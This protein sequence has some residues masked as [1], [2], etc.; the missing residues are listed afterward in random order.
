[1]NPSLLIDLAC[2]Q[3]ASG[4]RGIGRFALDFSLNLI[5]HNPDWLF[6]IA[7]DSRFP[8]SIYQL[9]EVFKNFQNCKPLLFSGPADINYMYDHTANRRQLY[10]KLKHVFYSEHSPDL[11]LI[12]SVFEGYVDDV[13]VSIEEK[14]LRQYKVASV[15]HDFI[16]LVFPLKY[17][18]NSNQ[19]K[20]Y[21]ECLAELKKSDIYLSNSNC[22]KT[23]AQC[24]AHLNAETI[25]TI[26]G[27]CS[28]LFK[29]KMSTPRM[30]EA[31]LLKK[32]ITKPYFLYTGNTDFR[33]NLDGL[34]KAFGQLPISIREN[35]QCIVVANLDDE[36]KLLISNTPGADQLLKRN[37]L[38]FVGNIDDF[39][40][41]YLYEKCYAFVFPSRYEGLGFP[42]L[43]A[44]H[45]EKPVIM[46]N[47]SSL[48]ELGLHPDFAF[49]PESPSQ[50]ANLMEKL[51]T[52][53]EF[54]KQGVQIS[55]DN[56][57]L[58][59]WEKTTALARE[60]LRKFLVPSSS[61]NPAKIQNTTASGFVQKKTLAY[62]S[63]LP[64]TRSGISI[65]SQ[66]LLQEL[67]NEFD[68]TAIVDETEWEQVRKII[69]SPAV[70]DNHWFRTHGGK[71]DI[72]LYQFGNS[73]FHSYMLELMEQWPGV[74]TLHDFFLPNVTFFNQHYSNHCYDSHGYHSLKPSIPPS[75]NRKDEFPVNFGILTQSLGVISHSEFC[76]NL[77]SLWYP[78]AK[79]PPWEIVPILNSFKP[80]SQLKPREKLGIP[81]TDFLICSFGYVD[82]IKLHHIILDAVNLVAHQIQNVHLIFVGESGAEYLASLNDQSKMLANRFKVTGWVEEEDY[83]SFL[84]AS[85][86]VIQLRS[87]PRGESSAALM[88]ALSVGKTVMI[89]DV[90]SFKEIPNDIVLKVSEVPEPKEVAT[91]ILRLTSDPNFRRSLGSK[92]KNHIAAYHSANYCAQLYSK[93]LNQFFQKFLC[94]HQKSFRDTCVDLVI[95]TGDTSLL[96]IS[97]HV[98]SR[99][100]LSKGSAKRLFID[101]T[102]L[103]KQDLKTGIHRVVKKYLDVFLELE[104]KNHRIEPIFSYEGKYRYARNFAK[105]Y[106]NL[107]LHPALDRPIDFHSE[108]VFF[109][110]DLCCTEVLKSRD[111]LW[112][113][114]ATGVKQFFML[115]DI[116]PITNPSFF[117]DEVTGCFKDWVK[118]CLD[119]KAHM[120][121]ISKASIEEL[122]KF[123]LTEFKKTW[124]DSHLR[125]NHLGADFSALSESELALPRK[126]LVTGKDVFLSVGTIEPRKGFDQILSAFDILWSRGFDVGLVFVGKRGWLCEDLINRI[127]KHPQKGK[128]FLWRESISDE[129]LKETYLGSTCYLG[130]SLGEGFGLP[131]IEAAQ[132]ELPLLI[133]DLEVFKEIAGENASYFSGLTGADLAVAVEKWLGD[134]T[135]PEA[136][137][138]PYLSWSDSAKQLWEILWN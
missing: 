23:D 11:V 101:I 4:K 83:A 2:V 105:K 57:K 30:E 66:A 70:K 17:L 34:L 42:V 67:Q 48:K 44:Y 43:E 45:S 86:I 119:L 73:P 100:F 104:D 28:E 68:I 103:Q 6:T 93:A 113:M 99:Q 129:Q 95:K 108:D 79:I 131:L 55:I 107:P 94:S 69:K 8:D 14:T 15:I 27:D 90:G 61:S 81:S 133:R 40:L 56:T 62:V 77:F 92:A 25:T 33:K 130:A 115:Y 12:P 52:S 136:S 1:M 49:D 5:R 31:Y 125:F 85:D 41:R 116:L 112:H 88:D 114:K 16:P 19:K 18:A 122:K 37:N 78:S 51:C 3:G 84:F 126:R 72:V 96:D 64:P 58:F 111:D 36:A 20:W 109:G 134:S 121:G 24:F 102:E 60:A 132:F 87:N 74:V 54:Y 13:I 50:I 59:S 26:Y 135:K 117:N 123:S 75:V 65:Y 138:L 21:Q 106:W 89:N 110:L 124:S 82:P 9:K 120:I 80:S 47:T 53:P 63:P 137:K 39:E 71:F 118:F 76:K 29:S 127:D 97:A 38:F 46:S 10:R 98:A 22:T 7:L 91:A 35:Y 128:R 32:G